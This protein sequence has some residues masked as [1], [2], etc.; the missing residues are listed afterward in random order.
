MYRR[1]LQRNALLNEA[2]HM[3]A[4]DAITI[5]NFKLRLAYYRF[6]MSLFRVSDTIWFWFQVDYVRVYV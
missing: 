4:V 5:H 3:S 2:D 6:I 1:L